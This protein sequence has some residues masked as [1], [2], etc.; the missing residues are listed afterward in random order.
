MRDKVPGPAIRERARA[1]R[2]AGAVL[3]ARFRASQVGAV[4]DGLTLAGVAEAT[5]SG[6]TVLTDNYLRVHL[7]ETIPG[8]QRVRVRLT[9]AGEAMT[10]ERIPPVGPAPMTASA[11]RPLAPA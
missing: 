7:P 8:N 10:G 11:A 4:R 9:G 2:D 1:L 5:G 6:T 3:S